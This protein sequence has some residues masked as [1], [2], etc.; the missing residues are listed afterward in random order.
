MVYLKQIASTISYLA[1]ERFEADD[2]AV[3]NPINIITETI[4]NKYY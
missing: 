3:A 2:H 4:K 1:D